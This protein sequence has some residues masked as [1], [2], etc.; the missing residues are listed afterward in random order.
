MYIGPV[1]KGPDVKRPHV[2]KPHVTR[3]HVK[4]PHS[5][6]AP[7]VKKLYVLLKYV[8]VTILRSNFFCKYYIYKLE[9]SLIF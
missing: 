5:L 7:K 2:K 9:T 3:P 4:R 6:K 8:D 1:E